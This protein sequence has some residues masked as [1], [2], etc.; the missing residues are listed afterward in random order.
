MGLF[1]LL[2]LLLT[3]AFIAV[4]GD[5]ETRVAVAALLLSSIATMVLFKSGL[6]FGTHSAPF[7]AVS[8]THLIVVLTIAYRSRRFWPLLYAALQML[9]V[10]SSLGPM[11][12]ENLVTYALGVLQG[13]WAYPQLIILMFAV[14]RGRRTNTGSS[15]S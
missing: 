10:A 12:A 8:L 2:L 3:V 6:S 7:L 14:L 11:F 15:V 9:T 4:R 1:Y 5:S 13:A